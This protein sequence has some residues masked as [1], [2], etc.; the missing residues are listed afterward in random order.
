MKLWIPVWLAALLL[1]LV[2]SEWL[3]ADLGTG[4]ITVGSRSQSIPRDFRSGWELLRTRAAEDE[5]ALT[6]MDDPPADAVAVYPL[7]RFVDLAGN[8]I[9][10]GVTLSVELYGWPPDPGT[11]T[12]TTQNDTDGNAAGW[13]IGTYSL[14]STARTQTSTDAGEADTVYQTNIE[15]VDL[16]GAAWV[17]ARITS[18]GG[19]EA[20]VNVRWR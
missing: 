3:P 9:A 5:T 16:A 13:L 1:G 18:V 20:E 19:S 14:V 17:A 15:P 11:G 8:A 4:G 7:A 12:G 2:M 10:A 6:D